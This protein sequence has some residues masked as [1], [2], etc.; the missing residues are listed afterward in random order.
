MSDSMDRSPATLELALRVGDIV[1]LWLSGHLAYYV[2]F[3]EEITQT[4]SP[5]A[6][7]LYLG[8]LL[9][10]LILPNMEVYT[11]WRG[12][13]PAA[14]FARLGLAWGLILSIG[15][16]ASFAFHIAPQLS[17]LWLA[18]W[19]VSGLGLLAVSRFVAFNI[20]RMLKNRG[21]YCKPVVI[22]GYGPTGRELHRRALENDWY[23]YDVQAVYLDPTQAG[24]PINH[25][26]LQV[27][28]SL[29][30]IGDYVVA[31]HIAE[32]WLTLPL[33][34]S[35]HLLKL[36]NLLRNTLVDVRLV[37][38][39]DNV[40]ILSS[41][42]VRFFG[43]PT[44]D[45]NRPQIAGS[46]ALLKDLF[47]RI[48]SA[49]AL[50]CLA[51]LL[52]AIALAVKWTSPGPVL[53]RQRRLG[54]NGRIFYL[55]K[56]R[57]MRHETVENVRQATSDDPRITPVG[58]FLRRT[59]LD[60]LPQFFNVLLG[61]M[62]IVGPRPHALQHN[63]IYMRKLELY[64]L[65]HRVKPGITGWAQI[66]GYRGETDTDDKMAMRVQYDIHYIK[67]W[68]FWLDVKIILLTGI[69]GW[70]GANAY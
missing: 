54:L 9:A 62:S 67:N 36:R 11:A 22:V 24:S 50:A 38:D 13:R 27:L 34:D 51:P 69:K 56:F 28:P 49:I 40:E 41:D 6:I 7:A 44:I 61:D 32:V 48:F 21:L 23:G 53:F 63:E 64:M 60:E 33:T 55:Y 68:S 59:S 18:Y 66:N 31:N 5:Y 17:R 19:Y 52:L 25:A 42:I 12:R 8:C 10:Y 16:L 70:S 43:F 3:R 20:I 26:R 58:R 35:A 4:L 29:E 65:R 1:L 14:I 39:V 47:D 15:V 46:H 37:P 45:L 30:S 2:R 57:S